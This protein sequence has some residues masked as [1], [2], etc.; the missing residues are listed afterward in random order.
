MAANIFTNIFSYIPGL[1]DESDEKRRK[2]TCRFCGRV[3]PAPSLL[4]RH[5][6]IHTGEKP[7][8]CKICSKGF[9]TK[10]SLT[11]HQV[12]HMKI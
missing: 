7:F 5:E 11:S 12:V 2:T 8:V 3:F 10:G 4:A 1:D 6:R 9:T